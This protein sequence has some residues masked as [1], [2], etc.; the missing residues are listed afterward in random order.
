MVA[1]HEAKYSPLCDCR[2]SKCPWIARH[3]CRVFPAYIIMWSPPN[4]HVVLPFDWLDQS[5]LNSLSLQCSP[6]ASPSPQSHFVPPFPF[7]LHLVLHIFPILH[8]PSLLRLFVSSV[9]LFHRLFIYRTVH[10]C[11]LSLQCVAL[12]VCQSTMYIVHVILREWA[13]WSTNCRK[14]M[15]KRVLDPIDTLKTLAWSADFLV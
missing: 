9:C 3:V 12:G 15:R 2:V 8:L 11:E 7:S 10:R 14:Y 4:H 1:D 5:K 6:P 13:P